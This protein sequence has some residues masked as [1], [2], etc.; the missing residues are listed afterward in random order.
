MKI[1]CKC[2]CGKEVRYGNKFIHGHNKGNL[3][4][5]GIIHQGHKYVL[6]PAPREVGTSRYIAEHITKAEKVLGKQLPKGIVVH[7]HTEEQLV[8]CDRAYHQIIHRRTRAYNACG[9][10]D[11]LWCYYCKKY[12]APENMCFQNRNDK[13]KNIKYYHQN[14]AN[15]YIYELR[16]LEK[17]VKYSISDK[18]ISELA[19]L[20]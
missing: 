6:N 13:N 9:H 8:I 16:L 1:L 11:W 7:H 14:C 4:N 5:G 12:D 15:L 20:L 10:V 19:N 18:E 17:K 3:K 2:G